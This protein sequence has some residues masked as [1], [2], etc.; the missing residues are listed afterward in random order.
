MSQKSRVQGSGQA[1]CNAMC[2]VVHGW[3]WSEQKGSLG[4]DYFMMNLVV[5]SQSDWTNLIKTAHYEIGRNPAMNASWILE[6]SLWI[7]RV[8]EAPTE[9]E[10]KLVGDDASPSDRQSWPLYMEWLETKDN[11][12]FRRWGNWDPKE[13][14]AL[15]MATPL[16]SGWKEKTKGLHNPVGDQSGYRWK[17]GELF[18]W[19]TCKV[20]WLDFSLGLSTAL[21]EPQTCEFSFRDNSYIFLRELLAG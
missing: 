14:H 11:L 8:S 17:E 10:L 18:V 9:M 5:D 4:Q 2:C 13:W 3:P 15:T 21:T 20:C 7:L 6:Q 19:G 1:K 16:L 12:R